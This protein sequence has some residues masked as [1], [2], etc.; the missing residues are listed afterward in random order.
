MGT[1]QVK[2]LE[3]LTD[4]QRRSLAAALRTEIFE[5]KTSIVTQGEVAPATG[6]RQAGATTRK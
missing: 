3:E 4:P 1:G 6:R 5:P 2:I